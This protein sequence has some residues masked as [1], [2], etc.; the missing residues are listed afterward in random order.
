MSADVVGYSRLMGEDDEATVDALLGLRRTVTAL[1]V[2]R[3]GR[4]VDTAGDSVLAEFA[5]AVE[6]LRCAVDIQHALAPRQAALAPSRRMMLR[7]GLNLG[8]ILEHAGGLYGDG[9]NIAARLQALAQPGGVCVSGNVQEQ[10]ASHVPWA[11]DDA[12][13]QLVKNIARPVRAFHLRMPPDDGTFVTTEVT[14]PASRAHGNLPVD[15]PPLFGRDD[16]LA[17]LGGLMH[18]HRLVTVAGPG[19]VG[20]TTLAQ[21]FAHSQAALWRDGAWMV[22]LAALSDGNL[23][24]GVVAKTIGIESTASSGGP[25][26]LAATLASQSMLL[27]LDNCE[28]VVAPVSV[29]VEQLLHQAPGVRVLCTSQEPLHIGGEQLF[30]LGPLG[31]PQAPGLAAALSAAAV[32]LFVER[33]RAL[34]PEFTLD[35]GL[36]DDAVALCRKLDGLPLA[37]ELAA[38]RVPLLGVSGVLSRLGERLRMLHSGSRTALERHR[39]LRATLAWSHNLLEPAERAIHRRIGVFAG[40]FTLELAQRTVAG[41]DADAWSVLDGIG[42]LVDRSLL[43]AE[44]GHPPRY[45]LLESGRAFAIEQLIETGEHAHYLQRHAE[46]VAAVLVDTIARV[47]AGR[48]TMD[49]FIDLLAPEI[50][51]IRAAFEWA[52][53][54]PGQHTLAL[55]IPAYSVELMQRL[56]LLDELRRW[57][58]AA[59]A[60]LDDPVPPPLLARYLASTAVIPPQQSGLTADLQAQHLQRAEAL[61]RTLG[62]PQGLAWTLCIHGFH[63]HWIGDDATAERV[64]S[65]AHALR[66]DDWPPWLLGTIATRRASFVQSLDAA[67]VEQSMAEGLRRYRQVGDSRG[68]MVTVN[69][70]MVQC[71]ANDRHEQAIALGTEALEGSLRHMS[72]LLLTSVMDGLV[73]AL[74]LTGDLVRAQHVATDMLQHRRRGARLTTLGDGVALLAA[75]QGR[76]DDAARLLGAM[77]ADAASDSAVPYRGR[78]PDLEPS[79]MAMLRAAHGEDRIAR[80]RAEGAALD[81]AGIEALVRRGFSP[82]RAPPGQ[83]T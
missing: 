73:A 31:L 79:V 70:W 42:A 22:E 60:F 54:T 30:R 20:K 14:P 83:A 81:P 55:T 78:G 34:L 16:A 18:T 61:F 21:A 74:T 66:C 67:A 71:L 37:I 50:D 76:L 80:W 62:D 77:E 4:I 82:G 23:V 41:D 75:H 27:V 68:V 45:R 10:V 58:T 64:M 11:F 12:G 26:E 72:R 1:V 59:Q 69:N 2:A 56:D 6:A 7:I 9:V 25:R 52:L 43:V 44:S 63:A 28:H 3:R 36:C 53:R 38:A 32:R 33:V 57:L 5:S 51:N 24:N 19:G 29:L 40:G 15:L 65:E 47:E 17:T 39:T 48:Q 49:S 46:G 8:D 13:E 35:D